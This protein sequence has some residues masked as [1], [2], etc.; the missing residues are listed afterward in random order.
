MVVSLTALR[1]VV[2]LHFVFLTVFPLVAQAGPEV[3]PICLPQT[4]NDH[5]LSSGVGPF[6]HF[7]ASWLTPLKPTV[8]SRHGMF[9]SCWPHIAMKKSI[10]LARFGFALNTNLSCKKVTSYK[11]I[12]CES[13]TKSGHGGAHL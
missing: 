5:D 6:P 3:K 10:T 12:Y 2:A 4:P 9:Y 11:K 8:P 7:Q 13:V 1:V